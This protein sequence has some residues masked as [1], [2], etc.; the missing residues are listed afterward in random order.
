MAA[1]R[2][3]LHVDDDE[4]IL[5]IARMALELVDSFVLHQFSSGEA[6]I[7]A[8]PAI[9]PDLLLL[10]VMMPDMTGPQIWQAVRAT[11]G[12]GDIATVFMT[13]KAEDRTTHDLLAGGAL[14]VITKPFD[15][16]TLGAQIRAAWDRAR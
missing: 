11:A 4:D 13:A 9:R 7:A 6:A 15:P 14:A 2:T 1:P 10:D 8:A 12:F 5:E 16:M 3:I